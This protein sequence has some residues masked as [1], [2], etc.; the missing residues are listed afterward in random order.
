MKR[1]IRY[2]T[3][4]GG[5]ASRKGSSLPCI[6]FGGGDCFSAMVFAR[7]LKKH[8]HVSLAWDW[9][10]TAALVFWLESVSSVC[11]RTTYF[12]LGQSRQ[13]RPGAGKISMQRAGPRTPRAEIASGVEPS[14]GDANQAAFGSALTAQCSATA[15]RAL[16]NIGPVLVFG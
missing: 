13:S 9:R 4:C 1:A 7:R 16:P 15:L 10:H 5:G 12:A 8:V 3:E 11:G 2:K 14:R 6:V